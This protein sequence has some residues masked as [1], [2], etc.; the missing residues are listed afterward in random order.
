M[1]RHFSEFIF[2][3]LLFVFFSVTET[4]SLELPESMNFSED[5]TH[6]I[7]GGKSSSGFYDESILR[8]I[9]LSFAQ[10]DY[11]QQMI[12]NYTPQVNIPADLSVD[13]IN[14]PSVGARFKGFTSYSQTGNSLKKSFNIE[15]DY[16]DSTQTIMGYKTLNFNNCFG[17]PSF[18]REAL[19][20]NICRNYIPCP[21]SNLIKLTVNGEN[22]GIYANV[23]QV[24]S[25]FIKEWFINNK[26]DR[27][28]APMDMSNATPGGTAKYSALTDSTWQPGGQQPGGQQ[29]GGG[30]PGGG[31][32]PGGI[33]IFNGGNTALMWL[34]NS[35]AL[36]QAEYELKSSN[37]QN[38]WQN[39]I[40]ICNVLNNT[41]LA[42]LPDTLDTV[43]N[44]DRCL[45]FL[46]VENIFTD[47]DSY[48]TKGADY[49][50]FTEPETGRLN[51]IEYDGNESFKTNDVS[52]TPVYGETLTTRPLISRLLAVPSYR[53]R[54]LAHVRTIISES[55]DWNTL[56]PVIERYRALIG[57][58]VKADST[59]LTTN[60]AYES[61]LTEFQS[62]VQNRRS[63]L[64]GYTEINRVSPEIDSVACKTVKDENDS[65]ATGISLQVTANASSQNGI[66]SVTLHYSLELE[67]IFKSVVMY[68][69][70]L[71]GDDT[72]G[73]GKYCGHI[74]SIPLG[75][76][77]RYYIEAQAADTYNTVTFSPQGAEHDVYI[78][79]ISAPVS[80]NT[81][82]VINEIMAS[83][84]SSF[85]DPQGEYSDWIELK[86]IS[87]S[88]LDLSGMYL[89]DDESDLYKWV[90]P[91]GVSIEAGGYLL[92]FADGDE[93]DTPGL[94]S[95]FKLSADGESVFLTDSDEHG[96]AILD[97]VVFESLGDDISYGRYPDGAGKFCFLS[98]PTPGLINDVSTGVTDGKTPQHFSLSQ[99]YPNPFNSSTVISFSLPESGEIDLSVYNMLGQNIYKLSH[100]FYNSGTYNV[101]WNGCDENGRSLSSGIYLYRL[102]TG[103]N[104]IIHRLLLLR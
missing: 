5:G 97:S 100:G 62:F 35:E 50:F 40:N 80:G 52:L 70:G 44:V 90:I 75:S 98:T 47:E 30:Q 66:S 1:N 54:Y 42:D 101:R 4:Y 10:S 17:D 29:P 59:K 82:I 85:Q 48:L 7:Q 27:W 23:Q 37:A 41:A 51:T 88:L 12:N 96:N 67:G 74:T 25:T 32:Q 43:L 102:Q 89:S 63:F 31:Q 15:A 64:L 93:S 2:A 69:D 34:G 94:H 81:S 33:T 6:F 11:W 8:T 76:Y 24:N 60:A 14:Y 3:A 61:S 79:K 16:I 78:V 55:L 103:K 104:S 46:A 71:N 58:E 36:Y 53:Q 95:S 87:N 21:K 49:E 19:F 38:P 56:Q 45:W 65:S 73:D 99:N 92:V 86:N 57:D 91:D 68:D 18:I 28:K 83:N 84:K 39:L 72:A 22:R 9:N 26:G 13:G 20:F 77:V